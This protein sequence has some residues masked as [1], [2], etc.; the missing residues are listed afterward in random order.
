[1]FLFSYVYRLLYVGYVGCLIFKCKKQVKSQLSCRKW[2]SIFIYCCRSA[3]LHNF[4]SLLYVLLLNSSANNPRIA[5]T[6][7]KDVSESKVASPF[8]VCQNCVTPQL[9]LM[10]FDLFTSLPLS[11]LY[12][13]MPMP[14][15]SNLLYHS[16]N[17]TNIWF[18]TQTSSFNWTREGKTRKPHS[19]IFKF[20]L[21]AYEICLYPVK[22]TS[23]LFWLAETETETDHTFA[24]IT[25]KWTGEKETQKR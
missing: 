23:V 1:M 17:C 15:I 5:M 11:S 25:H 10:N 9:N 21:N 14:P 18:V 2:S 24:C 8:S 19:I 6:V 22:A 20:I 12:L 3:P 4:H 16:V 7:D 13:C